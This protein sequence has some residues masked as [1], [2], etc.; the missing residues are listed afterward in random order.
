MKDDGR[1][2]ERG[3]VV[4]SVVRSETNASIAILVCCCIDFLV[5]ALLNYLVMQ[6]CLVQALFIYYSV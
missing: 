2:R 5:L 6:M 4:V 3:V 1:E